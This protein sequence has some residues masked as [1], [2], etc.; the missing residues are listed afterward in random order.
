LSLLFV[1][2][3]QVYVK[4]ASGSDTDTDTNTNTTNTTDTTAAQAPVDTPPPSTSFSTSEEFSAAP[5]LY[6][7]QELAILAEMGF[8]DI[9]TLV[10]LLT[11][12]VK[13]PAGVRGGVEE[14]RNDISGDERE[15]GEREESDVTGDVSGGGG[16]VGGEGTREVSATSV[17][18]K[19]RVAHGLQQVLSCLLGT[20]VTEVYI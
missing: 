18:E 19:Q 16:D 20:R 6:W 17:E 8:E 7:H 12:F 14:V 10:P 11:K 15:S 9:D 1:S 3:S 4:K 13:H 5:P 2:C